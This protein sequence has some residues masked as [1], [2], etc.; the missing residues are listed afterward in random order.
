MGTTTRAEIRQKVAEAMGY[1]WESTATAN[2]DATSVIDTKL[3]NALGGSDDDSF[4]DKYVIMTSGSAAGSFGRV[5]DYA[6]STGDLTVASALSATPGSSSTYEL[7]DYDLD[8]IHAAIDT[9]CR[10]VFPS[11]YVPIIDETLLV[12]NLVQNSNMETDPGPSNGWTK[13]GDTWAQASTAAGDAVWHGTYSVKGTSGGGAAQL[14]QNIYYTRLAIHEIVGKTLTATARI[15]ATDANIA[16]IRVSFDGSTYS[17]SAYHGGGGEWEGPGTIYVNATI[18]SDPTE[19]SI[20]C[21]VAAGTK[22]A[23]FDEVQARINRIHRYTIPSTIIQGPTH[24]EYQSD[25]NDPTGNWHEVEGWHIIDDGASTRY[26]WI[27]TLP[28]PGYRLRLIGKGYLTVSAS[29]STAIEVSEG[30][31]DVIAHLAASEIYERIANVSSAFDAQ[32]FFQ[33]AA[34]QRRLA[35]S[36]LRAGVRRREGAQLRY[37][38]VLL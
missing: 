27:D 32:D 1:W 34:Q 26:L 5:S 7:H 37:K 2:G 18:P 15:W 12:D 24:V 21:E 8:I 31:V 19:I 23:F 22:V 25:M 20:W 28:P 4:I 29:D 30:Q 36:S 11:L 9:A 14:E 17:D 3:A 35:E 38:E 33:R 6:S 13:T 10:K 16:R